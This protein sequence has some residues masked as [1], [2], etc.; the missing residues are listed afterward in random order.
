MLSGSV[1]RHLLPYVLSIA[2][3]VFGIEAVTAAKAVDSGGELPPEVARILAAYDMP[4]R[5]FS[6]FVQD[7]AQDTP[8]LVVNPDIARN[9]ASTIKLLTTFIALDELNPGFRWKSEIYL[10]GPLRDGRL[11]G[12]LYIKGYGDPY[13]VIERYWLLLDQLRQKGVREIGGDLV[14]DNTYFSVPKVDPGAFDGQASRTYNVNPDAFLVNF[15]AVNFTF[16]PDPE[17]NRVSIVA[18]PKLAN[19]E[20]LNRLGVSDRRCGGYQNGIAIALGGQD[21]NRVTFSGNLGRYCREYRT[22][23]AVLQGPTYAYGLFRSLWAGAGASLEGNLRVEAVPAHLEPF[24]SFESLALGDII[25]L[26]NKWSNNVMA[27]HLLLTLGAERFGAPATVAN[28]RQAIIEL[29]R[30]R[31]LD[32]PELRIDN[33]AG[34]SRETRISAASL[35]RVLLAASDS[36]FRAE[37]VSSLPLSGLDGTLRRRFR[38]ASLVGRMHIKTGRLDDVFAMAGFVRSRSGRE[39]AVVAIQNEP[40]AHRGPGEE[41]Q[42]ALLKWV[43]RQ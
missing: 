36:L 40:G 9:P 22:S 7:T 38:D 42:S 8:L 11:E 33:G 2:W 30:E 35:G 13:M 3:L 32:F 39:F 10:D 20:L 37:F 24:H 41:A 6:V 28:G 43:Y 18:V 16:H 12:D 4:A 31:G 23:R 26:I 25:R 14:I 15:Q 17:S 1:P 21:S 19:L 5:T 29:L 27:R 34:L